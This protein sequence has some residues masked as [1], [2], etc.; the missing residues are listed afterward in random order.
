MRAIVILAVLLTL[1]ATAVAEI[2]A[3]YVNQGNGWVILNRYDDLASCTAAAKAYIASQPQG[4]QAGCAPFQKTYMLRYIY[5]S[6]AEQVF[7]NLSQSECQARRA[8][9]I[10]NGDGGFCIPE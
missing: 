8:A 5:A 1:P 7:S 9:A 2:Q 6:G 10:R 4:I 3:L